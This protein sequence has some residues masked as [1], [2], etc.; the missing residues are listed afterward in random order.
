MTPFL[1][2]SLTNLDR[3]RAI[4]YGRQSKRREDDSRTSPAAQRRSTAAFVESQP[5]WSM[6]PDTDHFED[7]GISGYDPGAVRPGYEAMMAK[8]RA[9]EAD[10]LV[11]FSLSRLTRQGALEAL[12]I[13]EELQKYGVSLVSVTERFLDTSDPM[14]VAF[15][16][17]IAALAHQESR[18]KSDFILSA[19]A[20]LKAAGSHTSGI[21]P[22]GFR[23]TR[24]VR[25]ELTVVKLVPH[26]EEAVQVRRMVAWALDGVAATSISRRLN[27]DAVPTKLASLGEAGQTRLKARRK[28]AASALPDH[29]R[30]MW[31]S[32]TVLRVLRDPRLAGYAA[33]WR[34]NVN[35]KGRERVPMRTEDGSPL[36][37][38][39]GIVTPVEWL[40]V[41]AALNS[42]TGPVPRQRPATQGR[43]SE[44]SLMGGWNFL[45]CGVCG[46]IMVVDWYRDCY[47]CNRRG[48]TVVPGHGGLGIT[49]SIVDTVVA[50]QV[51]YRLANADLED[52]EDAAWLVAAAQRFARQHEV[53]DVQEER[54]ETDAALQHVRDSLRQLYSD[55]RDGLY[56]GTVG[57]EMFKDT[58]T[59]YTDH[60]ARCVARLVELDK[61]SAVAV[62]L[63][64]D[65]WIGDGDWDDPLGPGTP[66]AAWDIPE[67]RAFLSFFVERVSITKAVGRGRNVKTP[68]RV[69]LHWATLPEAEA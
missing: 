6:N 44:R 66:W 10:V 8:V 61:I 54:A 56:G 29:G 38:H 42:R 20:E 16:A 49:S 1:S 35:G 64:M 34:K 58:L 13:N 57:T 32:S 21:A 30:P 39:G 28:N 17:L 45:F 27:E 59:R 15:F 11:I 55:R 19:K 37:A 3:V 36:V 47:R 14:G 43:S 12:R 53:A 51:W 4:T 25:G 46:S 65:D 23:S 60:E 62:S 24:E 48:G 7:V 22:Y 26:E 40:E 63:P 52:P 69:R 67:R 5:G 18:N 50:R 9:G 33:E 41:C 31:T 2:R 68:E